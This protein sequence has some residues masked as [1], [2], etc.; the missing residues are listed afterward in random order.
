[1]VVVVIEKEKVPRVGWDMQF[2]LIP[3]KLARQISEMDYLI[4]MTLLLMK[5]NHILI[6]REQIFNRERE[7]ERLKPGIYDPRFWCL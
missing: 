6:T 4:L 2:K 1:M 5:S 3:R 7:R